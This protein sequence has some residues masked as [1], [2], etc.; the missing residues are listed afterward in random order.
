GSRS[1]LLGKWW[2]AFAGSLTLLLVLASLLP[3]V[4]RWA[5]VLWPEQL[6]LFGIVAWGLLGPNWL[7]VLAATLGLGVRLLILGRWASASFSRGQLAPSSASDS[8][9]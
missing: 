7:T 2:L 3:W 4:E 1:F 9:R 5:I 6:V 8:S